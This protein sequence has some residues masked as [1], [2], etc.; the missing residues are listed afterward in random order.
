MKIRIRYWLG[1]AALA[2]L[3]SGAFS[4]CSSVTVHAQAIDI[5][6]TAEH[7]LSVLNGQARAQEAAVLDAYNQM[8]DEERMKGIVYE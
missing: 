7:R 6:T 3:F 2:F 5:E 4:Q 1:A 8:G